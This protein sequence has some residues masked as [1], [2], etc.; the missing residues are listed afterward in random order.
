MIELY[1]SVKYGQDV[2]TGI[3]GEIAPEAGRRPQ[4]RPDTKRRSILKAA[5]EVFLRQG[6]VSASMDQVA[7]EAG[8]S[9]V[10]IY[11]K[12]GTK[13]EL[14]TAIVDEICEQILAIEIVMPEMAESV[15]EGLKDLA[16]NY[17]RVLYDPEVLALVRLAIGENHARPDLGR[18]YFVSGPERARQGMVAIFEE[19]TARGELT[20]P[21]A[22][23]A[24]DQFL[25][26]LQ[27][28]RFYVLLDPDLCPD[29]AE[30]ARVA[31]SGVD[32]FLTRYA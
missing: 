25:A 24:A 23:L 12:F 1:R 10:T 21:D 20:I 17:A 22:R 29:S 14:F 30:I 2:S 32:L 31:R 11:S 3:P 7:A 8:V 5:R 27:P 6:F 4:T 16:V 15:E 18:L 26:L 13:Q 28:Q 9:K 19:L